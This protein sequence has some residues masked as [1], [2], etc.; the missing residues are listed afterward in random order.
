MKSDKPIMKF[1]WSGKGTKIAN[2]VLKKNKMQE[3]GH[4]ISRTTL[5]ED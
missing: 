4:Q 5:K 3:I 1:T 2:M